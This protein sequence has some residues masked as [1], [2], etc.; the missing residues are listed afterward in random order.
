L[1]DKLKEWRQ[2]VGVPEEL[3]RWHFTDEEWQAAENYSTARRSVEESPLG[4]ELGSAWTMGLAGGWLRIKRAVQALGLR[5]SD[6]KLDDPASSRDY[7]VPT[8]IEALRWQARGIV[9]A[10]A[11]AQSGF[12]KLD[13]FLVRPAYG[14]E[15]FEIAMPPSP[16][17]VGGVYLGGAG[18]ILKGLGELKGVAIDD[19]TGKLVL[20]ASD[21]QRAAL[22]PLRLDDVVTVFRAVYN[23]GRSPSVTIDPDEEDPLGPIMHVKHGPGTDGTYVGWILFECDR[24]MKTYQLGQDNVSTRSVNSQIPGYTMTRDAVFFGDPTNQEVVEDSTPGSFRNLID[25][26]I[27]FF[28]ATTTQGVDKSIGERLRHVVDSVRRFLG[29]S[30]VPGEEGSNWERFWIVPNAVNRFDAAAIDLSFFEV[31]LKVNTQKMH[32]EC[33]DLVDDEAG[34]SSFGANAF[35]SWFTEYYDE[36][37]DEVQL[38]PPPGSGRESPIPIFH[39][40]QRIALIAAI[41][42]RLRELGHSMP[43]WMRDYPVAPLVMSAT[44]PSLTV[45]RQ[46]SDRSRRVTIYGGVNLAPADEDLHVYS[47]ASDVSS[48]TPPPGSVPFV[49]AS[50]RE[51]ASLTQKIAGLARA[52]DPLGTIRKVEMEDGTTLST[53]ILSGARTRALAPNRQRVTDMSVP[54]GLG[55]RLELTRFYNS[56]FDPAGE[57]GK[58]WTFDL[59]ELRMAR[60]PVRRDGKHSQYRGVPHLMSPLSSVDIRFDEIDRVEPYGT[61]MYVAR[62]HPEIL[63]VVSAESK[64]TKEITQRVLFRDGMQWHFD[65]DGQ[66]VI[67]ARDGI[68]TRYVRDAAGRLDSIEGYVGVHRVADIQLSYDA[69]GRIIESRVTQ[70]EYLRKQVPAAVAMIQYLYGEDGRLARVTRKSANADQLPRI[71]WQYVYESDRLSRISESEHADITFEY[72]KRGRVLSQ[73]QGEQTTVFKVTTISNGTQLERRAGD[74]SGEVE[75][76]S[77]DAKLRPVEADLGGSRTFAWRYG[78]GSEVVETARQAGELILTRSTTSDGRTETTA[79]QDGPIYQVRKDQAG[80]TREITRDTVVAAEMSWRPDGLLGSLR[81]GGTE[82]RPLRHEDGWPNGVVISAPAE[83]GKPEKWFKEEWDA[84]GRPMELSDFTGLQYQIKYDGQ[85]RL[86]AYGRVTERGKRMGTN[87]EYDDSG[88]LEGIDSPWRS[89]H[90]DYTAGGQLLRVVTE[91]QGAESVTSYGAYGREVNRLGFDGESTK[92]L[93]SSDEVGGALRAI[94]LPNGERVNYLQS[95]SDEWVGWKIGIGPAVVLQLSNI[96]A[97]TTSYSW[98]RQIP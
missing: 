54:I 37:A 28:G 46:D 63:G 87:L 15:V 70:A 43:P 67:E 14:D 58:G 19:A 24:I 93:Y 20:I 59:P 57:L 41:A 78:S 85:G 75:T 23:H 36:I 53:T 82:I 31:P 13:D 48:I 10:W 2:G 92:W 86:I 47:D 69:L 88:R 45:E 11:G 38:T 16:S 9:D 51:A 96:E 44:T 94:E 90:R 95:E 1:D 32:W 3:S 55:R 27:C 6:L 56:F 26:W 35:T 68:A 97:G 80:R 64:I 29:D 98:G 17:A 39:E 8:S 81:V 49:D 22:P 7:W 18:E 76:W 34:Q 74:E 25:S 4:R 33:G 77:Y 61:E 30:S 60:V 21:Q 52:D 42:E 66:F 62:E 89:E 40:L 5:P 65:N 79:F 72:D 91:R 71:R 12:K 73:R 84:L 83:D 50:S